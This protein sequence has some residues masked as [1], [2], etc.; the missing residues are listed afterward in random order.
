MKLDPVA[1][2]RIIDR[3]LA[4]ADVIEKAAG[5][6]RKSGGSDEAD[7]MLAN[8][9]ELMRDLKDSLQEPKYLTQESAR[10]FAA[11]LDGMIKW[12]ADRTPGRTARKANAADDVDEADDVEDEDDG[13]EAIE[14]SSLTDNVRTVISLRLKGLASEDDVYRAL[15][16]KV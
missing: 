2:A 7:T 9:L 1:R 13:S 16:F 15:H 12:Y 10:Q 11:K 3:A 8:M 14:K 6:V 4:L 5:A